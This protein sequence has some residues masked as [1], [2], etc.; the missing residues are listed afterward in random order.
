ML[1]GLTG[2]SGAGKSTVS[3]IFKENGFFV[4]NAD[5]VSKAV[6]DSEVGMAAL[7]KAFGEEYFENGKLNR[8]KLGALVFEN[9]KMLDKLNNTLLPIISEE[10]QKII[11]SSDSQFVLIDA[12][13]LFE[14][15]IDKNC[16]AVISVIAPKNVLINRI[17]KRD[18]LSF[19]DAEKRISSQFSEEFFKENSQIVIENN[20]TLENL[21]SNAETALNNLLK[22]QIYG[23]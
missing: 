15:G 2:Q 17:M 13:T 9:K 4:I 3:E 8:K 22:K 18:S 14:S 20:S 23:G 21:K 16:D 7:K 1:I 10:I 12:P 19:N 6:A 5:L 11:D